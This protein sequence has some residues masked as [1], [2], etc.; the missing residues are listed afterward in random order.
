MFIT[1]IN[2]LKKTKQDMA[3][4]APNAKIN[5]QSFFNHLLIFFEAY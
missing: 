2:L 4:S 3:K 1:I 5:G